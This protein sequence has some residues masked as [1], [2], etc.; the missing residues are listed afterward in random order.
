MWDF[1]EDAEAVLLIELDGHPLEVSLTENVC[2]QFL[3]TTM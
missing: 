3:I 2:W 1:P